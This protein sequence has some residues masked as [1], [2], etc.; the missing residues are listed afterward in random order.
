[1]ARQI[2]R[3]R[4]GHPVLRKATASLI[5]VAAAVLVFHAIAGL[6]VAVFWVVAVI[7]VIVAVV[8]AAK[9]LL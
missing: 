1:M 6:V 3:R 8:W 4:G 2:E 7:A 5:V 9:E